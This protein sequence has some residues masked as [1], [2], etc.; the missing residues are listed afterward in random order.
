VWLFNTLF[1]RSKANKR[2]FDFPSLKNRFPTKK[3]FCFSLLAVVAVCF[4]F[5]DFLGFYYLQTFGV[6]AVFESL[7]IFCFCF[8][9]MIVGAVSLSG[10][11]Q[12]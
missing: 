10:S 4:L 7:Y 8:P 9:R 12:L 3:A 5:T 2:I 11:I 6:C 1:N